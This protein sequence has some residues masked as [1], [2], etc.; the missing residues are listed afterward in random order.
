[1]AVV[2]VCILYHT[3]TTNSHP[4]SSDLLS[5][6]GWGTGS[7]KVRIARVFLLLLPPNHTKNR[8]KREKW[9]Y[10]CPSVAGMGSGAV[11]AAWDGA[12]M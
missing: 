5:P 8:V 3:I 6:T 10:S 1:M 12:C 11:A 4:G 7:T 2:S 9:K